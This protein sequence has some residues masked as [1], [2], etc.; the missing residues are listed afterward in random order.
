MKTFVVGA[1]GLDITGKSKRK[2]ML[3][4]SNPG[5]IRVSLGCVAGNIARNLFSLDEDV[6]LIS[7]VG[8]DF[9]GNVALEKMKNFGMRTDK[10]KI[11]NGE[12]ATYLA[13]FDENADM[14]VAIAGMDILNKIDEN[15]LRENESSLR[16]ASCIATETNLPAKTLEWLFSTFEKKFFV[17]SVSITKAEKLKN[18]LSNIYFLKT[19]LLEASAILGERT[20]SKE[21]ILK[22]A[23]IFLQK[24]VKNVAITCGEKGAYFFSRSSSFFISS[25]KVPVVNTSGAG[26]AFLSGF[27]KA[28]LLDLPTA[29]KLKIAMASSLLTIQSENAVSE[30]LNMKNIEKEKEK[31]CLKK[32]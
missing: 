31:I 5:E 15:L 4:D 20:E 30:K 32:L 14:K 25:E 17:D 23:S 19:N 16:S 22:S 1:F 11:I 3:K 9:N 28:D 21:E 10:I 12:T 8:N 18:L 2:L 27:L 6:T 29:E 13:I 7:A 24:G 26:D